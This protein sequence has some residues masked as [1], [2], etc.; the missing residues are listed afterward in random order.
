MAKNKE[1]ELLEEGVKV[2]ISD[3][4]WMLFERDGWGIDDELY[5]QK[6]NDFDALRILVEKCKD[7]RL[8]DVN[9]AFIPF[10]KTAL[11][12]KL[13]ALDRGERVSLPRI[14]IQMQLPMANAFYYALREV[15][16][17]PLPQKSSAT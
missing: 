9:Q 12:E 14:P 11:L 16:K 5:F 8:M 10:D 1:V 6:S 7:W 2:A 15:R 17:L 4:E 3:D 13:N